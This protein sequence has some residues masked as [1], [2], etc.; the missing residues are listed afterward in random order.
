MNESKGCAVLDTECSKTVC[1]VMWLN[2]Y[3]GD[4]SD[5]ERETIKEENSL[6]TFTFG[7]G[8]TV[9]SLKCVTIPCP[10]GD[11]SAIISTDV[12]DCNI[13]LLMSKT[14]MKKARMRLDFATDTVGI[15]GRDFEWRS[16]FSGHFVLPLFL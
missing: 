4:L 14:S 1:G 5:Y 7:D 13:P 12:V 3:L 2:N 15:C 6:A 9:P 11:I 16:T 8:M 10:M